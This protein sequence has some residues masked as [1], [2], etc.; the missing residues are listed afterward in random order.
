MMAMVIMRMT[1]MP[2]DWDLAI[3]FIGSVIGE[4]GGVVVG[5]ESVQ[6]FVVVEFESHSVEALLRISSVLKFLQE[7][8]SLFKLTTNRLYSC[9]QFLYTCLLFYLIRFLTSTI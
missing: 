8:M 4:L 1:K 6:R 3:R 7:K 9:P 5:S 2:P